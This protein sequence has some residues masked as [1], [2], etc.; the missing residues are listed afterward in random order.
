MSVS[1]HGANLI[2]SLN[3][4]FK[5]MIATEIKKQVC[6]NSKH[7]QRSVKNLNFHFSASGTEDKNL[8]RH[9]VKAGNP[10]QTRRQATPKERK[11]I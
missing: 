10:L 6:I 3:K 9:T 11:T 2:T 5:T 7:R 4:Y 1:E 8:Q